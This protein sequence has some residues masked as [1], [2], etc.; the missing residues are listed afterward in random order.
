[1]KNLKPPHRIIA[2]APIKLGVNVEVQEHADRSNLW[3]WL[4]DAGVGTARTL[5]PERSLRERPLE[6][7][8]LDHIESF[9]DVMAWREKL[10]FDPE[11][12]LPWDDF[13][14]DRHVPWFGVPD[15]FVR[16]YL[17]L[18]IEPMI[19]LCY[20]PGH[21]PLSL[22]KDLESPDLPEMHELE[23]KALAAAW[24][25]LFTLVY[26][27]AYRLGAHH[28]TTIN[29]PEWLPSA[30]HIAPSLAD[31]ARLPI[32]RETDHQVFSETGNRYR[33]CFA[34][35]YASLCRVIRWA[36]DDVKELLRDNGRQD[37]IFLTGPTSNQF[38]RDLGDA[39]AP[40][41]DAFD[42]HF[43]SD[44]PK[45]H[46]SR[47]D[48]ALELSRQHDNKPVSVGEFN[49]KAGPTPIDRSPFSFDASLDFAAMLEELHRATPP[50][51]TLLFLAVY[52]FAGPSTHRSFK[53][54]AY[55]DLN[56]LSWDGLDTALRSKGEEWHPTFEELQLRHPTAN[57]GIFRMF[58]R[59]ATSGTLDDQGAGLLISRL[60]ES[61]SILRLEKEGEMH[62]AADHVVDAENTPG[63][64]EQLWAKL[65]LSEIAPEGRWVAHR[66]TENGSWDRLESMV[67]IENQTLKLPFRPK[68]LQ[69]WIVSDVDL[70]AV[71]QLL[72]KEK[73]ITPGEIRNLDLHQTT[74]LEVAGDMGYRTI[75]LGSWAIQWSSSHPHLVS[76]S[77]AGMVQRLRNTDQTVTIDA[78]FPVTGLALQWIV[79]PAGSLVPRRR[80]GRRT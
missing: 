40:W 27:F 38:Y 36:L 18:G 43:Y 61:L 24:Q 3:D 74:R 19:S 17:H 20:G 21:F 10:R 73:S 22:V 2:R 71:Y 57:L 1:M 54:L 14:F 16:R 4:K 53:H 48:S 32:I 79:P 65:D 39:A 8:D 58:S 66:V 42:H 68:S 55:G 80:K 49:L 29:E 47:F 35:Q 62:E 25:N 59:I 37:N 52:L 70:G 30:F 41:L 12:Q 69:Q 15:D 23:P 76:V 51:Q 11:N 60:P 63:E 75:E 26:H 9:E 28:F 72:T 13:C 56:S 44:D 46:R 77:N 78:I 5:H 45:A 64:E 67:A 33:R 50:E 31:E 6:L 34:I 7:S